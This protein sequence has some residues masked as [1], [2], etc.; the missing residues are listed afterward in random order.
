MLADVTSFPVH[1]V[2]TNLTSVDNR[3]GAQFASVLL[4][5]FFAAQVVNFDVIEEN[6]V[7]ARFEIANPTIVTTPV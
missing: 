7:A 6:A 1:D 5:V 2:S 3:C 4:R